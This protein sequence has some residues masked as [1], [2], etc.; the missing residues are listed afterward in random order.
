V[1]NLPVEI[2]AGS[3]LGASLGGDDG[4]GVLDDHAA[5]RLAGMTP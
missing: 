3:P 2:G 1:A 5:I 4:G